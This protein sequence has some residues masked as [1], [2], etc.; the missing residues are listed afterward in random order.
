MT[1]LML[2]VKHMPKWC[3]EF[4]PKLLFSSATQVHNRQ[5]AGL[6]WQLHNPSFK[7]FF[8]KANMRLCIF[9]MEPLCCLKKMRR[10]WG[11]LGYF[12]K[13]INLL[14]F[15]LLLLLFLCEC[16]TSTY[17]RVLELLL[18]LKE[19]NPYRKE[20]QTLSAWQ[21]TSAKWQLKISRPPQRPSAFCAS[22]PSQKH[23]RTEV[24]YGGLWISPPFASPGTAQELLEKPG[25]ASLTFLG[26]GGLH[27]WNGAGPQEAAAW[28]MPG[29]DRHGS[30]ANSFT[31]RSLGGCGACCDASSHPKAPCTVRTRGLGLWGTE[32]PPRRP[33]RARKRNITMH[34]PALWTSIAHVTSFMVFIIPHG[35]GIWSVGYPKPHLEA[36]RKQR[37]F[38]A[39]LSL[40]HPKYLQLW[41][42][43]RCQRRDLCGA[44]KGGKEQIPVLLPLQS[45]LALTQE[46]QR[47][48]QTS[49]RDPHRGHRGAPLPAPSFD[50][51]F[52][53]RSLLC[54]QLCLP[55]SSLTY[56]PYDA[57]SWLLWR[58]REP[59]QGHIWDGTTAYK[60]RPRARCSQAAASFFDTFHNCFSTQTLAHVQLLHC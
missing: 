58:H 41:E 34:Q 23:W 43:G 56:K 17:P 15:L 19:H 57:M 60:Y 8:R 32:G 4:G 6:W 37:A 44:S 42:V 49:S 24:S 33:P 3:A 50:S 26:L 12:C 53:S 7:L 30:W 5:T 52:S 47:C 14:L 16:E 13:R 31:Q 9:K 40:R 21:Q 54:A 1:I 27:L 39:H 22:E 20:K 36:G 28:L 48:S 10:F 59:E 46:L 38:G 51:S 35:G 25:L 18:S 29:T 11:S 2:K 55:H 45:K